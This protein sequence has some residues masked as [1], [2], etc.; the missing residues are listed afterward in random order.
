MHQ[1]CIQIL[2]SLKSHI[3]SH[4][5]FPEKSIVGNS[6]NPPKL[7]SPAHKNPPSFFLPLTPPKTSII[8]PPL[9]WL[10]ELLYGKQL[11]NFQPNIFH[12]IVD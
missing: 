9:I 7:S 12:K 10:E 1:K 11:L 4:Q 8:Y 5:S 3:N 6:Q 2:P